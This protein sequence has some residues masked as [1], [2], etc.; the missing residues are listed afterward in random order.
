[1]IRKLRLNRRSSRKKKLNKQKVEE[2]R[3]VLKLSLIEIK[4]EKSLVL[5][6]TNRSF[7]LILSN[8]QS[9]KNK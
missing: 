9:I 3:G 4:A 8:V 2:E 5:D 7:L 1:M 6:M